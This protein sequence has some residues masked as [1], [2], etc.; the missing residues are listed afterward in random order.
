MSS[1]RTTKLT[2]DKLELKL[3]IKHEAH[4]RCINTLGVWG[5]S[6]HQLARQ[7]KYQ[8]NVTG[9]LTYSAL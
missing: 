3:T 1:N 9:W 6:P 2:Q 8:E 5:Q 4:Y 7:V